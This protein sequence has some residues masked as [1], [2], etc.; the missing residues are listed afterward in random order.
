MEVEDIQE[1][2]TKLKNK[3]VNI[4][5]ELTTEE[6]GDTHFTVLDPNGIGI[7]ILQERKE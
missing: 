2:F 1:Y 7:D 4:D 6:W 5:L 3:K